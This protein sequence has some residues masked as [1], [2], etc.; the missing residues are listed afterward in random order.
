MGFPR[1]I[2]SLPTRSENK[3]DQQT[4]SAERGKNP[5]KSAT[6]TQTKTGVKS[7]ARLV[8]PRP[9]SCSRATVAGGVADRA[10]CGCPLWLFL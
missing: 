5:A 2:L 4:G 7:D 6:Q 9:H 1:Q 10:G 8:R 3:A